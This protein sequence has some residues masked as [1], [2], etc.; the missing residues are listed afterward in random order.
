MTANSEENKWNWRILDKYFNYWYY[1]CWKVNL[2]FSWSML[3]TENKF[4]NV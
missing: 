1:I 4:Y 3:Y 2:H